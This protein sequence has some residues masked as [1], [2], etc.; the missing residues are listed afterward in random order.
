MKY[1]VP[2][3]TT[4]EMY[5]TEKS[6]GPNTASPEFSPRPIFT[7]APKVPPPSVEMTAQTVP[8]S[9]PSPQQR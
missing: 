5:D 8:R 4:L 9:E 3:V 7:G 1:R 6:P 2:A